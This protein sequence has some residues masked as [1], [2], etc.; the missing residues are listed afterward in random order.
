LGNSDLVAQ[1]KVTIVLFEILHPDCTAVFAF[2]N[3]A[4][5]HT[6][7]PDAFRASRLNLS[8]GGKNTPLLK[9]GWLRRDDHVIAHDLHFINSSNH[10]TV[11]KGLGR[12]LQERG[13]WP[14]DRG[15]N[16]SESRL[17]LSQPED[18]KSQCGWSEETASDRVHI[19]IFYP[20]FHPEF[21]WIEMFWSATKRFTR[22]HCTYSFQD[23]ERVV[24]QALKATSVATMRRFARKCL[25]YMNIYRSGV[26][27]TR[28]QIEYAMETYSSHRSIPVSILNSL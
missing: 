28:K 12:I 18:F 10:T 5:H 20:K 15:L 22:K 4:N 23:L 19:I 3:S 21:N 7:A 11:H 25:R 9:N 6:F 1:L 26:H 17:L 8:D 27:L 24:P 14:C 13:L 2:D 16:L